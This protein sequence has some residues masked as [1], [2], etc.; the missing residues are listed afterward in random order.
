MTESTLTLRI[1]AIDSDKDIG[2]SK[3]LKLP[4]AFLNAREESDRIKLSLYKNS[5]GR[6]QLLT[7]W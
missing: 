5:G 6:G 3:L 2:P 7:H 1:L 4:P